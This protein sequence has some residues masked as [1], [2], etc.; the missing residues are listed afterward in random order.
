MRSAIGSPRRR[1]G[2]RTGR[3]PPLLCVTQAPLVRQPP[4]LHSP[5]LACIPPPFVPDGDDLPLPCQRRRPG[6][7]EKASA[8]APSTAGML[9]PS[10]PHCP[11]DGADPG[12]RPRCHPRFIH[13]R[14][15]GSP[16]F[17]RAGSPSPL[18]S[19][20]PIRRI[21]VGRLKMIQQTK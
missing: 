18:P 16:P 3:R 12:R 17:H 14:H 10:L 6:P 8:W 9:V 2:T 15:A 13:G 1:P 7:P 4:S 5:A 20:R 21:W 11:G 19:I